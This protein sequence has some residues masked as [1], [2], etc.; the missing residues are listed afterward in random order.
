MNFVYQYIDREKKQKW[1]SWLSK[2]IE[3][4]T[5]KYVY[6]KI[7]YVVYRLSLIQVSRYR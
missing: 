4:I 2:E 5:I 1:G 6:F 3:I 7:V